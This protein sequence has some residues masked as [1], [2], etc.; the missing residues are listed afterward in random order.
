MSNPIL[1]NAISARHPRSR[2]FCGFARVHG[3]KVKKRRFALVAENAGHPGS[4]G[5]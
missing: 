4:I 3:T 5:T 1:F 2:A